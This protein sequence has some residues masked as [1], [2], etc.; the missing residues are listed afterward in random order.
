MLPGFIDPHGHF[1]QVANSLL[2]ASVDGL[3]TPEKMAQAIQDYIKKENIQPG[4]WVTIKEYDQNILPNQK[5]PTLEEIDAMAPNNPIIV[6]HK[7]GHM[8]L[9]N[10]LGLEKV[11]ITPNTPSPEGG[12]IEV[13]DGKLTG[14]LEENAF[15]EYM[16]QVPLPS[17]EALKKAFIKAQEK[18][19]SYG[20][21]TM[22]E[23]MVVKEIFPLYQMLLANKLLYLDL[24]SYPEPGTYDK[25]MEMFGNLDKDLH[26]KIG[27]VKIFA[28]G[29]PQGR[30]AWMRK[31]YI[32]DENYSGY[33]TLTDEVMLQAMEFAAK[34]NA[35]LLCHCNG[36]KAAEQFLNC[37]EKTEEK[38]PNM[39]ELRPV[40]I[41]GQLLGTD[42]LPKVKKL[43]AMVSF[44]VAHVW[45]WGDVHIRNFGMDRASNISAAKS[46]LEEGVKFTFHQD[47]SVIQPDMLETVWCA[48]NRTT[49]VGASLG[50]NTE[51]SVLEVL[52]A[53]LINGG[54]QYF[55]ENEKCSIAKCKQADLVILNKNPL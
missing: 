8:G 7:S 11:G 13:V 5:N 16:K 38:Y 35:Q 48:V 45:H 25:A 51:I 23:G 44:F 47:A 37:L 41:H 53:I 50:E 52:K 40:I 28:D 34:N 42:Q 9:M 55:Q 33:G 20:I 36:D 10:S 24:I 4:Q 6:Q 27:G 15:F 2:Q 30:T 19:A 21:T 39:K 18:Y 31:P 12:M 1:S 43:Q 32:D 29:S 46:A 14:Y 26:L 3:E 49:K 54:Y 17:L 22:Q